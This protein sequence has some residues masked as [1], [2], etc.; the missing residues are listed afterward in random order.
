MRARDYPKVSDAQLKSE[1]DRDRFQL[2]LT[3]RL[4]DHL[5]LELDFDYKDRKADIADATYSSR[6]TALKLNYR[7]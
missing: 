6:L 4:S 1:E 7:R 3:T 2:R 5:E